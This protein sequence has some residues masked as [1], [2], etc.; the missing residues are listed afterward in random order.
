MSSRVKTIVRFN[1]IRNA[2][3]A[4]RAE[5]NHSEP[6]KEQAP[7]AN[8]EPRMDTRHESSDDPNADYSSKQDVVPEDGKITISKEVS[9]AYKHR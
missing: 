9:L 5:V 2:L 1:L 6:H 7:E 4:R 3:A 8:G